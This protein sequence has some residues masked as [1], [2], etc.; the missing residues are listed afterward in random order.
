MTGD[1]M[2]RIIEKPYSV[3][4]KYV[5]FYYAVYVYTHEKVNEMTGRAT[6]M[7]L[8]VGVRRTL[9]GAKRW[10]EYGREAPPGAREAG[11]EVSTMARLIL[12]NG[13]TQP[14]DRKERAT[15]A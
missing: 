7:G 5:P 6:P 2:I 10:A 12:A 11:V 15:D 1:P 8:F 4:R 9:H 14:A 13:L 3:I